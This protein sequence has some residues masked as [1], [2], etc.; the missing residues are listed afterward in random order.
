MPSGK[1]PDRYPP[2]FLHD[3]YSLSLPL[4]LD[5]LDRQIAPVAANNSLPN[6]Y[7]ALPLQRHLF[8]KEDL[9]DAQEST[10]PVI[11]GVAVKQASMAEFV[12][13]TV[14]GLLGRYL[15]DFS[16]CFIGTRGKRIRTEV[17]CGK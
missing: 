14:A 17:A 9:L 10:G 13:V 4:R 7:A 3:I 5:L 11:G 2:V 16:G 15:G 12:T 1:S 6:L 8:G